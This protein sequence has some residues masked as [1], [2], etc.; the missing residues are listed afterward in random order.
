MPSHSS[1]EISD[2]NICL[3]YQTKID[4]IF[5]NFNVCKQHKTEQKFV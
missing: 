4:F 1:C 5:C 2:Y 3:F